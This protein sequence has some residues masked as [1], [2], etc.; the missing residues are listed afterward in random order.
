MPSVAVIG[1]SNAPHKFGNKAVR[2]YLRQGWTVYPV[3]PER[4]DGRGADG[5]PDARGLP[6]PVDRVS[7]YVPPSVGIT[8]LEAIKA[9]GAAEL[10]LN[11]GSE[12]DELVDRATRWGSSR[13]RPARSSTSANARSRRYGAPLEPAA[14]RRQ[15]ER[16]RARAWARARGRATAT[17]SPSVRTMKLPNPALDP[18]AAVSQEHPPD[19]PLLIGASLPPPVPVVLPAPAGIVAPAASA[20]PP[21]P[22]APASRWRRL[23]RPS[24][25]RPGAGVAAAARRARA[26]HRAVAPALPVVPP[27]PP[28]PVDDVPPVPPRPPDPRAAGAR[29]H[30]RPG[31][32][33]IQVGSGRGE[34]VP[35]M[36]V[37]SPVPPLV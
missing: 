6:G 24:R 23:S 17:A 15:R 33:R 14:T 29:R 34:R 25:S 30:R 19:T 7:M 5:L 21:P 18:D 28:V 20:V 16:R 3:N 26:A 35:S 13:F 11:P 37:G 8:L 36:Q 31:A 1:A 32:R 27:R 22:V 9:K 4:E 2:A 10:F 12:S